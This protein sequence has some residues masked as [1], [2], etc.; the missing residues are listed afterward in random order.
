M[1][2]KLGEKP[3]AMCMP[4]PAQGHIN[5]MLKLAKLLHFKGFHITFIHSEFNYNRILTSGGHSSLQ[6]QEDFRFEAIPDGLPP[7]DPTTT[8][9]VPTLCLAVRNNMAAPFR[10]LLKRLNEP[11]SGVPPVTCII[12]DNITSFTLEAAEEFGIP[13][14]FFCSASACGYMG[15]IQFKALEERGLV[16]LKSMVKS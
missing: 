12:S 16:P 3:H 4:Y 14:V 11:S 7:S 9:D 13:D 8:Q 5:G 10:E 2:S 15:C 1:G 6:G